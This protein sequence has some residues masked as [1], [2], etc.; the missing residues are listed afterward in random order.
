MAPER[1]RRKLS[2]ASDSN[3]EGFSES[4][5]PASEVSHDDSYLANASR[6]NLEQSYETKSRKLNKKDKQNTAGR[7]PIKTAEGRIEQ[8]EHPAEVEEDGD[9]WLDSAEEEEEESDHN[10]ASQ[11]SEQEQILEAKAELAQLALSLSQDPEEHV[12]AFKSLEKWAQ[13][14]NHVVKQLALATQL[15]V[16]KDVIPGYRIRPLGDFELAEKVSKEVKKQRAF[17]QS[18]VRSYKNYV[19]TLGKCASQRRHQKQSEKVAAVGRIAISCICEL[20]LAAP[21]FNFRTELLQIVAGKLGGRV[22]D[23][24]FA[25]C[26]ET[27]ETMFKVDEDGNASLEAVKILT[28]MIK[29]RNYQIDESV[30]NAFLCLRLLTEFSSKASKDDVDKEESVRGKKFKEN[31]TFRNKRQRKA[32]RELKAVEKDFTDAEAVASHE[33]RDRQQGEA[34]KLVLGTCFRVL[35]ARSPNLTGAVLEILA[36]YA[37]LINQDF[38]GDLLEV[39]RDLA[40]KAASCLDPAFS[41]S[42]KEES[43]DDDGS[44]ALCMDP[45][46]TAMLCTTTAFSLL[47]AQDA[48]RLSLDLTSFSSLLYTLLLPTLPLH[49]DLEFS[50]KTLRLPDPHSPNYKPLDPDSAPKV[51]LSTSSTLL[52]RALTAAL[53]PRSTPPTRLASFTHRLM[54]ASL[55]TPERTSRAFLGLLAEISRSQGRKIAPLWRSEERRGDGEFDAL[56]GMEGCKPYCGSVWEGELLRCHFAPGV[57]EG[58]GVLEDLVAGIA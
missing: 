16:F 17:E 9:S 4:D 49:P 51:N 40:Q 35:K 58:V 19:D 12:G 54:S 20:L 46:R 26:R 31:K 30:L 41:S 48:S 53:S 36:M 45:T 7:L 24:Q 18:L 3:F 1:K 2:P 11:K 13:S 39:L 32:L 27:I 10:E 37:H 6:W 29:E 34:L 25:K 28:R 42:V 55:H 52:I 44:L 50:H 57:R 38:F 21:H 14:P 15:T 33:Q 22:I 47:S 8:V 56:G 5:T 23:E 43:L